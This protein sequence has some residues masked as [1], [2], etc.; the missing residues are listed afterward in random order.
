MKTLIIGLDGGTWKVLKSLAEAGET[1]TLKKLMDDGYVCTLKSTIPP[2]TGVAWTSFATGRNPGKSGVFDFV[3]FKNKSYDLRVVNYKDVKC[4]TYFKILSNYNI[5]SIIINLP[6]AFPQKLP[7]TIIVADFLSHIDKY[8]AVPKDIQLKYENLFKKYRLS[9]KKEMFDQ[10]N[11]LEEVLEIEKIRFKIAKSLFKNEK[12]KHFFYLF[13]G[14]DWASHSALKAF[15]NNK[16]KKIKEKFI[17]VFRFMD[18][19]LNWFINNMDNNTNIFIMSDHGHAPR[20]YIFYIN[21]WLCREGYA[22]RKPKKFVDP[23]LEI[24]AKR[25]KVKTLAM[26]SILTKLVYKLSETPLI[27]IMRKIH[28]NIRNITGISFSYNFYSI[29]FQKSKAF[30]PAFS[31]FG[32][33]LNSKS[34]FKDGFIDKPDELAEEIVNKL[35]NLKLSEQ[36][37]F[38]GIWKKE[39]LYYGRYTVEAPD[40]ILLPSE[41]I[42]LHIDTNVKSIY[43]K[44][45]HLA[46]THSTDGIF[47]A[48]GPDI[49]ANRD[50]GKSFSIMDIAPTILHMHEIPIPEE[51]DGRVLKEIFKETSSVFKR[52][53]YYKKNSQKEEIRRKIVR[54]KKF[55]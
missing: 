54:L 17:K 13:S 2:Y 30:C 35:R 1:P 6:G 53:I 45:T 48:Y 10:Q 12:W 9:P 37:V 26:G 27:H 18:E 34:R 3:K 33:Y 14:T 11:Y 46:G 5:N 51:M 52:K 22:V 28:H 8:F 43:S 47:I 40:I 21:E 23:F 20:K 19:C 25:A 38:K 16:N 36:R 24:Q 7:R 32:I 55:V 42:E 31:T 50:L 44:D 41:G 39:E 29:D 15:Y 49:K 4:E